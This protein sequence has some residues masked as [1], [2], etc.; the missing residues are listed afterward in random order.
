MYTNE[1]RF[2]RTISPR[3]RRYLPRVGALCLATVTSAGAFGEDLLVAGTIS[4]ASSCEMAVGSGSVDLGSIHRDDLNPDPSK[5]TPL[6]V[7]RIKMRIDCAQPARYALVASSLSGAQSSDRYDFGL[8]AQDHAP[9]GKLF[10]RFDSASAHIEG[11]DAFYTY[12]VDSDLAQANW[13]PSTFSILP[14]PFDDFAMGFTTSDGSYAAPA[15]IKNFDTYLLVAPEIK[16]SSELNLT[17]EIAF[18]SSLGFEIR[19]F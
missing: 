7:R 17:D 6:G 13:G 12:T 10:I 19:Y 2:T 5:P 15:V 9:T 14:I 1:K 4:P 11:K 3:L 16:P 8:F 18:G